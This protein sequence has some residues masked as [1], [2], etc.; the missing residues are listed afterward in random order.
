MASTLHTV[1][2]GQRPRPELCG[3]LPRP[4]TNIRQIVRTRDNSSRDSC[5]VKGT[6]LAACGSA[7][8]FHAVGGSHVEAPPSSRFGASMLAP[9]S[10]RLACGRISTDRSHLTLQALQSRPAA[11]A[12]AALHAPGSGGRR[13]SEHA[14]GR[15]EEHTSELQSRLH[16]VCR[17]LLEKKKKRINTHQ[18]QMTEDA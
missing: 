3:V 8:G 11:C 5:H 6:T 13:A 18:H 14:D 9:T 2:N 16:L 7:R 4:P 12:V 1:D 17:L 10:P 15:S